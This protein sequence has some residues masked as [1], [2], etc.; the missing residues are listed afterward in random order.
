VVPPTLVRRVLSLVLTC[1]VVVGSAVA[2]RRAV[3]Q[4]GW[5][6]AGGAPDQLAVRR[7]PRCDARPARSALSSS[8]PVA[9]LPGAGELTQPTVHRAVFRPYDDVFAGVFAPLGRRSRGPPSPR[10]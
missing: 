9:V 3:S 1:A 6:D 8:V 5:N 7:A 4:A 2:V 10:S